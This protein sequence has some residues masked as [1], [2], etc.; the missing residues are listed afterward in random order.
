MKILVAVESYPDLQGSVSL[1]YV[2]TRNLYYKK[3]DIDITVLNFTAKENYI[4]DGIKVITWSY[5][6]HENYHAYG[7]VLLLHAPNLK[8]HLRFL[9]RYGNNFKKSIFFFHGHEVLRCSK[10]YSTPYKYVKRNLMYEKYKDIYDVLKLIIWKNVFEQKSNK[11][12][13]VFVSQWM[14]QEFLKWVNIDEKKIIDR[15]YIIYNCV[16]KEF[17]KCTY[18]F[19]NAKKYDFISI[20]SNFDESKYCVDIICKIARENPD[21]KF[22]LIGKGQYFMYN[23]K[24]K[25]LTVIS[26]YLH[27]EKILSYLNI[28]KCALMPTRTDAQGV[29]ACEMAT[30]GIPLITSDIPVCREVFNNFENVRFISNDCPNVNIL[31]LY[32]DIKKC[33][34]SKKNEKFF[35]INTC[36]KEVELIK[37]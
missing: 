35:E 9:K 12:E 32:T 5:Y 30:Y 37:L 10:V 33:M 24:P 15:K 18:D 1:C 19:S 21:A 8:H 14:Y 17:E 27:H 4:I 3:A 34:P 28:S 22:C 11:Y 29:M 25:N 31:K 13:F 23:K 26:E 2:H 6:L 7:D 16:G 20:R 36:K